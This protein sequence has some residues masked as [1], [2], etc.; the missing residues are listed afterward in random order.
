MVI[1]IVDDGVC[2]GI[3]N[4]ASD[5]VYSSFPFLVPIIVNFPSQTVVTEWESKLML[6]PKSVNA[7]TGRRLKRREGM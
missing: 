5:A 1:N 4:A 7:P 3:L 6:K 2:H